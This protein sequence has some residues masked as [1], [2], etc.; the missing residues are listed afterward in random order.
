[1][2]WD[3]VQDDV[4]TSIER[5]AGVDIAYADG[6]MYAAAVCLRL[7]DLSPLDVVHVRMHVSFPYIP[8]YLGYREFPGIEAAVSRLSA[9]PDVL[10]IDGHGRLHPARF[11]VACHAGVRLDLPT[12]GVAKHLL[13]G[14]PRRQAGP[15]GAVA[16]ELYRHSEGFAWIP[17]NRTRPIFVSV[18]HRITLD[19]ALSVVQRATVR[20]YPE[21]LRLADWVSKE[22]KRREKREKGANAAMH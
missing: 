7:R 8:G 17:P 20:G 15:Q 18:G 22:R 6:W 19:R 10:M 3:V 12:I 5:V 4:A 2:S 11:G 21:P 16:I 1:M 14:R 13:V 9:R